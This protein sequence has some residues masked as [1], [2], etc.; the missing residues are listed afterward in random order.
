MTLYVFCEPENSPIDI[1][2]D[3]SIIVL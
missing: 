2:T 3:I 1:I